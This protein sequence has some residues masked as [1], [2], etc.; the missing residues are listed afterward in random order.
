MECSGVNT[1]AG[2]NGRT[3][4]S[5]QSLLGFPIPGEFGF[6]I[7]RIQGHGALGPIVKTGV[8]PKSRASGKLSSKPVFGEPGREQSPAR[9]AVASARLQ[10]DLAVRSRRVARVPAMLLSAPRPSDSR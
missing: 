7:W 4:E 6:R 3:P 1:V 5:L 10:A 9:V 2:E 8:N